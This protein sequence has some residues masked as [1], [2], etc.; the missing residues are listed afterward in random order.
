MAI[1]KSLINTGVTRLL[2]K[3]YMEDLMVS[4]DASFSSVSASGNITAGD[5]FYS[6]INGLYINNKKA[7]FTNSATDNWLRINGNINFSSGVYFG[8][9]VV[10]TDGEL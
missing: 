9:S 7:I 4:G 6:G 10:R 3:V 5:A 2:G 8:N 1:L